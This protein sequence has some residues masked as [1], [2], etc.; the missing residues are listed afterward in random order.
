MYIPDL[1]PQNYS[2]IEDRTIL[3]VGWLGSGEK[4]CTGEVSEDFIEK[5]KSLCDHPI[6]LYRGFHNC[7]FCLNTESNR[8]E[9][10][11]IGNGEIRIMSD[12][13]IWYVAPKMIHHYVMV[14]NYRPPIE[15]VNCVLS[16][17]KIEKAD[18]R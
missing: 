9:W 1:S 7:E 10:A 18:E 3:S 12:E 11:K 8:R 15:F 16:P 2:N 13:G 4:Y 17:T 5:L 6:N 14:H